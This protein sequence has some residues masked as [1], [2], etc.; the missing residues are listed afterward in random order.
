M[1]A[2][3]EEKRDVFMAEVLLH[4]LPRRGREEQAIRWQEKGRSAALHLPIQLSSVYCG[5]YLCMGHF[6]MN[7]PIQRAFPAW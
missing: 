7:C 1:A 6:G 3:W 4:G 2:S 5:P